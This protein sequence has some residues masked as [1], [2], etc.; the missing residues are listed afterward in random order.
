MRISRRV[1]AGV[2]HRRRLLR[3]AAF[4]DDRVA[5]SIADVVGK[6]L[7]AAL[8]M[9]NLQAA[10][11]AFASGDGAAA[12]RLRQR[13][14]P[15]LPQHRVRQVRDVLL[16]RL[17]GVAATLSYANAGHYPP[18]LVR[19]DGR[20]EKLST[21][22]TVLG[23]FPDTAY[24]EAELP[25]VPGDRLLFYT[26][27][28][29]EARDSAGEE[30]GDDGLAELLVKHRALGAA[31]LH[32]TILDHVAAFAADGFQDDATIIAVEIPDK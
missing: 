17:D 10:V 26:D 22:G 16:R 28:I 31:A 13:Q 24:D 32:S 11:R 3:R 29:T 23:V 7:P 12:R 15:A 30:F 19:A 21:G 9:S 4:S 27:G 6:G 8:L 18:L 25:L 1:D 20:L 14:S 5:L 2:R